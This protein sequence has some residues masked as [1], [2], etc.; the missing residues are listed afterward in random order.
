MNK[1]KAMFIINIIRFSSKVN[2]FVNSTSIIQQN[3]FNNDN[4]VMI[5]EK[6]HI[7]VKIK[8]WGIE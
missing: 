2:I 6:E 4:R 5:T 8:D 7:L 3:M 1:M